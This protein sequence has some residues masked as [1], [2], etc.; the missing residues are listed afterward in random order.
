MQFTI[1]HN[2]AGKELITEFTVFDLAGNKVSSR[3]KRIFA[4]GYRTSMINWDGRGDNGK[5][6]APG[7]YI[8]QFRIT[9]PEGMV[10][11]QSIKIVIAR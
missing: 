6:L 10:A 5:I 11:K 7:M 3:N 1:G 8:A 2:Q 4:D 9:S